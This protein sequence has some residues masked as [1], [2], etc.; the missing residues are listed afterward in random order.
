MI[1]RVPS[2]HLGLG[3]HPLR[4][5]FHHPTKMMKPRPSGNLSLIVVAALSAF[6]G[7]MVGTLFLH[8]YHQ[9]AFGEPSASTGAHAAA[10]SG[11][12]LSLRST[13]QTPISGTCS[14]LIDEYAAGN[15]SL[16]SSRLPDRAAIPD[17]LNALGLTGQAVEVGVRDGD[18]SYHILKHWK[19][20][21]LHMVDPWLQQDAKVYQDV[22]NV[23]PCL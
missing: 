2:S 5:G 13:V 20:Q 23:S 11:H 22:S 17:L 16:V 18:H 8:F 19:G 3:F 6:F 4:L 10:G 21:M 14:A 7:A 1:T 9:L 15:R 12:G